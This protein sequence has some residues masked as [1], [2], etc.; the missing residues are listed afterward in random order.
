MLNFCQV[1]RNCCV[2]EGLASQIQCC[3][4]QMES[5][6]KSLNRINLESMEVETESEISETFGY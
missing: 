2:F 5:F 4:K 6:E 1:M 3:S